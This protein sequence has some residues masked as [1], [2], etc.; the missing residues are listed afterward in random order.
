MHF[1]YPS[2]LLGFL[3][4]TIFVCL[5]IYLALKLSVKA[6]EDLFHKQK[7]LDNFSQEDSNSRK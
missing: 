4:G 3:F 5:V 2:F 7:S 6:D 1:S